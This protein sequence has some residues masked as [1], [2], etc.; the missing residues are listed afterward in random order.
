VTVTYYLLGFP[1]GGMRPT[2]RAELSQF[3]TLSIV[4]LVFR[5]RVVAVLA[6]RTSER[7]NN[8]ILFA[9]S[10]HVFLRLGFEYIVSNPGPRTIPLRHGTRK[11][12]AWPGRCKSRAY[13][14]LRGVW[15]GVSWATPTKHPPKHPKRPASGPAWHPQGVPLLYDGA[16]WQARV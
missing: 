13:G 14:A 15:V 2:G 8:T 6:V 5:G 10:S 12:H 9:F 1:V 16:P 3:E 11:S 4:L 7:H